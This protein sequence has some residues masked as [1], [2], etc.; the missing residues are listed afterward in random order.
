LARENEREKMAGK[1]TGA[2]VLPKNFFGK[3]NAIKAKQD[4]KRDLADPEKL[5]KALDEIAT[6]LTSTVATMAKVEMKG[7]EPSEEWSV[8]WPMV[9]ATVAEALLARIE[10]ALPGQLMLRPDVAPAR[11]GLV[12]PP[13]PPKRAWTGVLTDAHVKRY[14]ERMCPGC[15]L[16]LV[17]G[18]SVT[19]LPG[20]ETAY[21]KSCA[22]KP[23]PAPKP[24]RVFPAAERHIEKGSV[25]RHCTA[26]MGLGEMMVWRYGWTEV[27]HES[28]WLE[29]GKPEA[30]GS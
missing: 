25:C 26:P 18:D 22:P 16:R 4:R 24:V 15:E 10:T 11:V 6:R 9:R 13:R 30:L 14:G 20:T 21:H 5:E 12:K 2:K 23:A 27:L 17:R 3:R 28:C 19:V 8:V 29:L 1:V 7:R